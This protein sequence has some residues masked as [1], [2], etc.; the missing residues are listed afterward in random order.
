[1]AA[2]LLPGGPDLEL[3]LRVAERLGLGGR[4]RVDVG[5]AGLVR[6]R[7]KVPVALVV[8]VVRDGLGVLREVGRA[9]VGRRPRV[10]A[11]AGRDRALDL[12]LLRRRL[13]DVGP[14]GGTASQLVL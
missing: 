3:G 9:R 1:M 8:L 7:R 14:A 10:G 5:P 11:R 6:R 12:R 4:L 13:A 2:V